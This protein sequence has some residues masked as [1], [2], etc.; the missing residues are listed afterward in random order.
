MGQLQKRGT[1]EL[2]ASRLGPTLPR[3]T[4]V[5]D[6]LYRIVKIPQAIIN[7][8]QVVFDPADVL[9]VDW[10]LGQPETVRRQQALEGHLESALKG[11][12]RSNV[13]F[14]R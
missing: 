5:L 13:D 12:H 3:L 14:S 7:G 8:S 1:L 11:P 6:P 4:A 9:E 10:G 2:N